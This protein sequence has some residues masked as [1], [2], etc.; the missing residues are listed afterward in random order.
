MQADEA[1][2]SFGVHAL[3]NAHPLKKGAPG[4]LLGNCWSH[5]QGAEFRV[6]RCKTK[7][8]PQTLLPTPGLHQENRNSLMP[9]FLEV[10]L[11]S[12]F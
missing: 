3:L 2:E 7:R 12:L 11:S 1:K 5:G 10:W 8:E 4:P 6:P 9:S